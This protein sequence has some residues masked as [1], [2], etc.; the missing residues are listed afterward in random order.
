[1]KPERTTV[2]QE[3]I[4][5]LE[6]KAREIRGRILDLGACGKKIHYGGS[7]SMVEILTVL[8]FQTLRHDPRRPSWEDRD[9][10]LLSKGHSCPGLYVVLAEAGYFPREILATFRE[11]DTILQG[12]PDRKKTPGV[13]ITSGSLG[14]GLSQGVGIALG[15]RMDSKSYRVY[16]LIGDGEMDEG[17]IWEAMLAAAH[18]NLDNLT[19]I[20]DRNRIQ[21][22]GFTED[23]IRLEPLADKWKAL[24]W[25]VVE[26]DGHSIHS[27]LDAFAA[28][29]RIQ[30]QPSVI[31][32]NTIKGKGVSF[33]ENKIAFHTTAINPEQYRD[34][35]CQI[36]REGN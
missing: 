9:R 30:G 3:Q 35:I 17:Q 13:E 27:L 26:A 16:V 29:Q 20:V 32:A 23:I 31:I 28:V 2:S 1:L 7:L 25:A 6:E 15:A 12:H 18:Y 36:K 10:F 33:M 14:Q 34:A 8:Y 22:A 19:V 4:I 5:E 21:S 24:G 11:L